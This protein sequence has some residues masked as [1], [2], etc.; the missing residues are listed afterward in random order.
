MSGERLIKFLPCSS[1]RRSINICFPD[2]LAAQRANRTQGCTRPG[3]AP[4]EGR[5]R[6]T[7]LCAVWLHLQHC[8]MV[9]VPQYKEDIKIL[10]TV[11]RKATKTGKSLEGKVCEEWLRALVSSAQSR[12][13]DGG[14]SSSQG[15]EGQR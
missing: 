14:C 3:T 8:V 15:A 9:W 4:C 1:V 7:V 5:G 2:F 12:R 11:Q 10:E 6:P 13:A